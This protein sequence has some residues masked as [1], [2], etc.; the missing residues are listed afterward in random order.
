MWFVFCVGDCRNGGVYLF[1]SH[2]GD[3]YVACAAE[4]D[5]CKRGADMPF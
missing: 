3:S 2:V 4:A 1:L 5:L